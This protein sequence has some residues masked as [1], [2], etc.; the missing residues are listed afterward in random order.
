MIVLDMPRDHDDHTVADFLELLCLV[1]MD[2]QV[3][4]DTLRDFI[5]E[6]RADKA[7]R[8]KDEQLEDVLGQIG[9][10]I[11]AFE[12][13]YP[14]TLGDNGRVLEAPEVFTLDQKRY[15]A[16][17]ICGNLP[18]FANNQRQELTDFFEVVSNIALRQ[19]WSSNGTSIVVGKNTTELTGSKAERM[20]ALGK[21]LGG[22]PNIQ[23][24]DFRVGDRGDGGIDLAAFVTF[25]RWE[26]QNIVAALAQCACSRSDWSP[27]H[28]E[29]TNT[30]LRS[31][32][33]SAVPWVE[34]LFTPIS[35][36]SNSGKWAVPGDVPGVTLIDRLRIVLSWMRSGP[37][38]EQ[39][40]PVFVEAL[41]GY[42]LDVV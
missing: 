11:A 28:C 21:L 38:E 19:I 16:L 18:F 12:D 29:I 17:L 36:R 2:R 41:L 40:I 13:W 26:H 24:R 22:N 42:R 8:L 31:L 25:D 14:F 33:P 34:L 3:S 10:R 7:F 15:I 6:N 30:K 4:T 20:N 32:I 27:K 5:N 9:W 23:D 1:N 35:F 37:A 39:A